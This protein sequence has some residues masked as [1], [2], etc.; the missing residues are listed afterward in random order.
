MERGSQMALL[1][2]ARRS[3]TDAA[4]TGVSRPPLGMVDPHDALPDDPEIHVAR[5]AFVT[6]HSEDGAVRGCV[7]TTVAAK[8]LV[9]VV[10]DMARAAALRDPRFAPVAP[11]EVPRLKLEISVLQ[12]PRRV[13]DLA[14]VEIGRDGLLVVGRGCRGLLLPQVAEER[15][16]DAAT[17]A[18]HTCRK[19]GLKPEAYLESDVELYRFSA[20]VFSEPEASLEP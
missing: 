16:W 17:F 11:D 6:L 7:G 20:E 10:S 4:R 9:D 5:A 2:V 1:R 8:P 18:E 14:E 19:A 12:P 13:S 3:V 15:D